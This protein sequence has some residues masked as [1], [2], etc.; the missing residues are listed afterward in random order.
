MSAAISVTP[1]ATRAETTI[2]NPNAV[3][4]FPERHNTVRAGVLAHLLAGHRM[5][6]LEAVMGSSTTRLAAVIHILGNTRGGDY[7]WPI[8]RCDVAVDTRDGRIATVAEYWISDET[9]RQAKSIG[10]AAFCASVIEARAMGA[11]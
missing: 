8:D 4:T 5:R 9:I 3:G 2:A 7:M 1:G 10:A 6:S 11:R